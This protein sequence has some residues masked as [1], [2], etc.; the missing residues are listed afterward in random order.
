MTAFVAPWWSPL[1]R[2]RWGIW[3]EA[4]LGGVEGLK[5]KKKK[6]KKKK[7]GGDSCNRPRE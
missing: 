3:R 4:M 7:T 5:K 6:K 2:G 1:G